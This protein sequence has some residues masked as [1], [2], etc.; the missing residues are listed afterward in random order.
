M[1]PTGITW[2]DYIVIPAVALLALGVIIRAGR[3]VWKFFRRINQF[4]DS[5]FGTPARHGIAEQ[6][7]VMARL[8]AEEYSTTELRQAVTGLTEQIEAQP[9]HIDQLCDQMRDT[10]RDE[11]QEVIRAALGDHVASFH[12]HPQSGRA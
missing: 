3:G 8:A 9:Q 7:G 11:R 2:L 12:G 4:L 6:P 5:F 1:S 10:M